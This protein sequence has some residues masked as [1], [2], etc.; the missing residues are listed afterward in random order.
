MTAEF[1]ITIPGA[2]IIKRLAD[3]ETANADLLDRLTQLELT[4]SANAHQQD[5]LH[6]RF[7]ALERNN[8]SIGA[9]IQRVETDSVSAS[10]VERLAEELGRLN[11]R[12]ADLNDRLL[13]VDDTSI[14][15]HNH[16]SDAISVLNDLIEGKIDHTPEWPNVK[17]V[18]TTVAS[19]YASTSRVERLAEDLADLRR[20][21]NLALANGHEETKRVN[22]RL[23]KLEDAVG[24][25]DG[26]NMENGHAPNYP[27][28][29]PE[30]PV[31]TSWHPYDVLVDGVVGDHPKGDTRVAVLTRDNTLIG[32][33]PANTLSWSEC[34]AGTIV[35]WRYAKEG[36]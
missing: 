1:N 23:E 2:E 22:D 6:D 18:Q 4:V 19:P 24:W 8:E 17:P 33:G 12:V 10:R 36:E 27:A 35:A 13:V 14:R 25:T 29:D 30:P 7:I 28:N 26:A 21:L 9:Y 15:G 16:L 31:D 11:E 20:E 5:A 3:L 32:P 34:K